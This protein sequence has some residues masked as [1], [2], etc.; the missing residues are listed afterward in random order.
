MLK[1]SHIAFA[2]WFPCLF[3]GLV[4]CF[5]ERI[6]RYSQKGLVAECRAWAGSGKRPIEFDGCLDYSGA[7]Y[8]GG[9]WV[10]GGGREEYASDGPPG[11]PGRL[12]VVQKASPTYA[13][14]AG[15]G[16]FRLRAESTEYAVFSLR[17][18]DFGTPYTGRYPRR[19]ILQVSA[20]RDSDAG[21]AS[22][23]RLGEQHLKEGGTP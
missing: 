8:G 23:T 21:A 11:L 6:D 7:F 16:R 5:H 18:G 2:L 1:R 12:V 15:D 13:G 4:L 10:E 9:G 3:I 20:L 14:Y 22:A 19:K 17:H